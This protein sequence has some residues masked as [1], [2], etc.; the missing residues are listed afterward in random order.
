MRFHRVKHGLWGGVAGQGEKGGI[1]TTVHSYPPTT[2][3]A[4]RSKTDS[5]S[6]FYG[7]WLKKKMSFLFELNCSM[8]APHTLVAN[9]DPLHF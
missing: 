2:E 4:F 5:E 7:C 6:T 3:V 8:G 1:K 9:R